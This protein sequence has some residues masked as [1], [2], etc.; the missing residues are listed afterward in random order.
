MPGGDAY[1]GGGPAGGGA[2]GAG[3]GTATADGLAVSGVPQL[4][5]N[6]L[7]SGF[8][9]PQRAQVTGIY[10]SPAAV[11]ASPT[12]FRARLIVPGAAVNAPPQFGQK[13][14]ATM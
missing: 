5:Q 1:A 4:W 8:W 13:P 10:P 7:P 2:S 12:G 11:G 3:G 14:D 6:W 9:V